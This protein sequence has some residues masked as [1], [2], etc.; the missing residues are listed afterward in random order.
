MAETLQYGKSVKDFGAVGDG[1]ADDTAAFEAA[2]AA[3]ETLLAIPAGNYTI[4]KELAL[5]KSLV[6]HAHRRAVICHGGFTVTGAVGLTVRGGIWDGGDAAFVFRSCRGVT[7]E[8]MEIGVSDAAL[9]FTDCTDVLLEDAVFG[10]PLRFGGRIEGVEGRRLESSAQAAVTV[11]RNAEVSRFSLYDVKFGGFRHFFAADGAVLRNVSFSDI[12]GRAGEAA[13]NIKNCVLH[14]VRMRSL[15]LADGFIEL[16]GNKTE[17]LSIERVT[18]DAE[19][20]THPEKP[21][22]VFGGEE[23]TLFLDG[24]MLDAIISAKKSVPDAKIVAA[25]MASPLPGFR[26]TAEIP[27]TSKHAF[28]LPT[29]G[30]DAL[31]VN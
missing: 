17:G 14:G 28:R 29:G 31:S 10:C 7:L 19:T 9:S 12:R 20:D 13:I 15:T 22:L 3:G 11:E 5:P 25:R 23:A 8:S 16:A 27:L 1:K 21:T 24:V 18:R 4:K 30:W 6:I 26:Y 2:F